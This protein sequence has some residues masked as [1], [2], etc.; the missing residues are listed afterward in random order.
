MHST[1]PIIDF[2]PVLHGSLEGRERTISE[3][4]NALRTVGAFH[5][6]NYD[7]ERAKI[8]KWFEWSRRFFDLPLSEKEQLFPTPRSFE[9]GYF[10]IEKEKIRGQTALKENFDFGDSKVNI[11]SCW[12]REDQLPGFRDFAMDFHQDCSRLIGKLLECLS[13]ALKMEPDFFSCYHTGSMFVSSLLHYPAIS[14]TS[15]QPGQVVRNPVH[16]DFGTLT[17]L[18]QQKVDGLEVA[19]MSSTE[20]LSSAAVEKSATFI[21]VEP[22]PEMILVNVGYLLMRWTNARW[23]NSVHRVSAPSGSIN[24]ES[25]PERYSFAFFSYPDAQT[26]VEPLPACHNTEMPK[27]WGPINA[28][29]YLLSKR[30]KLYS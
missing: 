27:R 1:L 26:T 4:D 8:D 18:F 10:G 11:V 23:K 3:I 12:P 17:L 30:D 22:N 25:I 6:R 9:Q 24:S 19:D 7:I 13:V 28:G 20:E 16:S 14:S 2:S 21:P 15:V 5:L 29:E